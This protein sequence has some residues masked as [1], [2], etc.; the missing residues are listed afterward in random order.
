MKYTVRQFLDKFL[1]LVGDTTLDSATQFMIEGLNWTFNEL[2]MVPKLDRIFAR[3]L[4]YNLSVADGQYRWSLNGD[5][6][7]ITDIPM[8]NFWTSTG[9]E[10]CPLNLCHKNVPDFY[11]L[12]GIPY[13]KKA[14]TPCTYTLERDGDDLFLVLDRPNDIPI[15]IDYIAYGIPKPVKSLEDEIEI[16]SIAENLILQTLRTVWYEEAGDMAFAGA[17]SDYL[18]NK[19]IPQA[20]QMLNKQF[21]CETPIIVGER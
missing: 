2:P 14:G 3:H 11:Q 7:T 16:S 6:R 13:L 1:N 21:G 12:N 15:I 17:V 4:T 8:I 10:L 9:G 18:D 5:F 19:A 20:V